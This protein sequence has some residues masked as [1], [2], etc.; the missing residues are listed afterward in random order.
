MPRNSTILDWMR[1]VGVIAFA[2]AAAMWVRVSVGKPRVPT[3]SELVTN[4][5]FI[6]LVT[7][8]SLIMSAYR[9][10]RTPKESDTPE[11]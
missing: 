11:V 1:V 2:L 8:G 3:R 10:S 6:L 9:R 7:G 4:L 5:P